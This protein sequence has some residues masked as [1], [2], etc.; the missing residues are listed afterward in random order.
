MKV[1][2]EHYQELLTIVREA[3]PLC[4]SSRPVANTMRN[5][6]DCLWTQRNRS[7]AV[8]RDVYQY[9]NDTH[10]DTALRQAFTEVFGVEPI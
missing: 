4:D 1:K 9:A 3:K 2:P 5:R 6:W 8:I 10:L 7:H